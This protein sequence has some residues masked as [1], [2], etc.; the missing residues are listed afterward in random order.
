MDWRNILQ[1]ILGLEPVQH[2][3][4][5]NTPLGNASLTRASGVLHP[6]QSGANSDIE[7]ARNCWACQKDFSLTRHFKFF[8][9]KTKTR[10]TLVEFSVWDFFLSVSLI[11][12][13]LSNNPSVIKWA[14]T[15]R[16]HMLSWIN[17]TQNVKD[18]LHERWICLE[19]GNMSFLQEVVRVTTVVETKLRGTSWDH[20]AEITRG[21]WNF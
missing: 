6:L 1:L 20:S 16:R 19:P 12:L 8:Y 14:E 3:S 5:P 4:L 13:A 2:H 11:N 15:L 18:P 7:T 9:E 17:Y 10:G 21:Q